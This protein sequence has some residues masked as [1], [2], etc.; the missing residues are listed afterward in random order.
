MFQNVC[1]KQQLLPSA[2]MA[3]LMEKLTSAANAPVGAATADGGTTAA[4]GNVALFPTMSPVKDGG[5][6][7]NL[8]F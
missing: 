8:D 2:P 1:L 7:F 3:S 4:S 5:H 6:I